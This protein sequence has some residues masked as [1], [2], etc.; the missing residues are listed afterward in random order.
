MYKLI[1]GD[2]SEVLKTFDSECI[3]LTVTSP[4]YENMREYKGFIFDF[5][6]IAVELYRVTKNGGVLVWVVGDSTRNGNE[7]GVSFRQALYFQEIGFN[8]LDTM[9]YSKG[10]QGGAKGSSYC[11]TQSF[12]Y[13]FV[14]TKGKI[15]T[16]NLLRDRENTYQKNG[17]STMRK[18]NGKTIGFQV[19]PN[20]FSKRTNVWEIRGGYMVGSPDKITFKHPATYPELLAGDHILSWSN[21]GDMVLDPFV[22]SGTTIKLA[23]KLGRNSIGIDISKEYLL[24]AKERL[25]LPL[26]ASAFPDVEG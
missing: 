1:E 16:H 14:L 23:E 13:M 6:T 11:Y 26:F 19:K 7:S 20:E 3:D 4:P 21:V 25:E 12:E 15:K 24:I 17:K 2:C 10:A 5:E 22:G 18:K 8:L 9:I